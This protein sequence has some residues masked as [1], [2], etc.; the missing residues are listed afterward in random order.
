MNKQSQ[1]MEKGLCC[2]R[3]KFEAESP[4]TPSSYSGAGKLQR[5]WKDEVDAFPPLC[6]SATQYILW[7]KEE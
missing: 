2:F 3:R 7:S 4:G 1:L 6:P 5:Y